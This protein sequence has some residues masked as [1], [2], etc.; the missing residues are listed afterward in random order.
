MPKLTVRKPAQ[1]PKPKPKPQSAPRVQPHVHNLAKLIADPCNGPLVGPQYGSSDGGYL[2][3]FSSYHKHDVS[4]TGTS[5]Y[6]VW[7][8]D[9]TGGADTGGNGALYIFASTD[10][11]TG[12]VNTVADPLGRGSSAAS[13]NGNFLED[14]SHTFLTGSVVQDSRTVAACC[15]MIYTGRND[16][17]AGRVGYLD[18]IPRDALLAGAGGSPPSVEDMFRYSPNAMRTPLDIIENKFRPTDG[19][20]YYRTAGTASETDKDRCFT[21]G[22]GA[23]TSIGSGTPSGL[24][25]GIGFVW[26]GL[27]ADSALAFDFVK[28]VEWRPDMTSGLTAAP[29]HKSS[30]VNV[31]SRAVSYLDTKHPGWQRMALRIAKSA[32]AT[33]ANMASEGARNQIVRSAPLL[34]T[35]I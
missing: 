12:P 6:L 4:T 5:G 18:N 33:I 7:F 26:D 14:P 1:K 10:S 11:T 9:F 8:P 17:L 32:G 29:T 22:S 13:I 28:A 31:V 21:I 20:E 35:M 23:A 3:K 27:T 30:G 25:P 24:C 15:K 2:A 16:S 34:L 19:S